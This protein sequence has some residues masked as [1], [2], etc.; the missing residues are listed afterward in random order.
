MCGRYT[1]TKSLLEIQERFEI[2]PD[3]LDFDPEEFQPMYNVSPT[4]KVPCVI[5][6]GQEKRLALLRWGLIPFW[7][8]EA[9]IGASMINA[10]DDSLES[11]PAFKDLV[12]SNR[13]LVVADSFYE[14][15]AF[16]KTKRPVRFMLKE[17]ELFVFAGLHTSWNDKAK[18]EKVKSCTILTTEPNEV[19]SPVHNRMPVMLTREGEAKWL[20]PQVTSFEDIKELLKPLDDSLMKSYYANPA[21]NNVKNKGS[22]VAEPFDY[23]DL[24]EG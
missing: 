17:G 13:C 10:R 15:K 2:P 18:K 16:G 14:F 22:F 6:A 3:N 9:R 20:D 7:A 12:K 21:V 5:V 23:S 4:D 11:K 19:V 1:I 8:K 24:F